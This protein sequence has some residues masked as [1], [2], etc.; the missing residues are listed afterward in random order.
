MYSHKHFGGSWQKGSWGTQGGWCYRLDCHSAP[1]RFGGSL[2]LA[3]LSVGQTAARRADSP[4]RTVARFTSANWA[5]AKFLLLFMLSFLWQNCGP[6][7]TEICFSTS[8]FLRSEEIASVSSTVL[9]Q[10]ESSSQSHSLGCSTPLPLLLTLPFLICTPSILAQP[11]ACAKDLPKE[12]SPRDPLSKLPSCVSPI[13]TGT[14][15]FPN[16]DCLGFSFFSFWSIG[17][18]LLAGEFITQ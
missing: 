18:Y 10:F 14:V 16:Y 4:P 12:L 1:S 17:L 2:W 5:M 11:C 8:Q 15:V 3:P 7:L 6:Y 13:W 9:P